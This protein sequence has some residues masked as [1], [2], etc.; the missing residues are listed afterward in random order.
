MIVRQPGPDQCPADLLQAQGLEASRWRAGKLVNDACVP[1]DF[2]YRQWG[3]ATSV[4]DVSPAAVGEQQVDA[5]TVHRG[6]GM[7]QSCPAI[8]W[9]AGVGGGAVDQ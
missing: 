8:V 6:G 7:V 4:F 1:F 2:R 5:V 9:G 3:A